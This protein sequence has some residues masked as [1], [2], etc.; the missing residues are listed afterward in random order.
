MPV[1]AALLSRTIEE[2][3]AGSPHAAVLENGEVTFD[4][5]SARYAL[6][7]EHGRCLLH[8]W[9]GE[10][11]AVR[12]VLDLQAK[13]SLL[14]VTVQRFGQS[15]PTHLDIV[16]DSERRTP[17]ARQRARDHHLRLLERALRKGFPGWSSAAFSNRADL[18]RSFG[19]VYARGMLRRG[20]C[21]WACLGV[22]EQETRASV[23]GALT[24]GILWLDLLREKH[25]AELVIEGLRLFAPPRQ[26]RRAAHA[27]GGVEY[28]RREIR[29][30]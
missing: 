28:G 2:F 3:I 26:Q 8:L 10:R 24:L 23:D 25:A 16:R 20:R 21:A 4:F 1:D 29:A 27:H 13:A 15:K 12:R 22:N 19:P 11:N 5:S 17:V 30:L 9:S 7:A 14:R 6:S 18:E